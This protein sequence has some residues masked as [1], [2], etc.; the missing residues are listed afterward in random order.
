MELIAFYLVL[1]LILL[2]F[3]KLLPKKAIQ[4]IIIT[5][6]KMYIFKCNLGLIFAIYNT[7]LS[8][9]IINRIS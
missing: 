1:F 7:F 6:I 2:L 8:I 3:I 9:F 5:T 4:I